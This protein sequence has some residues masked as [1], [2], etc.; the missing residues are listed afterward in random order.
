MT[1]LDCGPIKVSKTNIPKVVEGSKLTTSC[2]FGSSCAYWHPDHSEEGDKKITN[3]IKVELEHLE[4]AAKEGIN[5]L[6][7]TAQHLPEKEINP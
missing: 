5:Q 2:R 4:K 7:A 3:D 1:N 6:K